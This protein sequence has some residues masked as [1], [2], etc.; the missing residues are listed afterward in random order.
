MGFFS[1]LAEGLTKTRNY[2]MNSVSNIFTGHDIIDDDVYEA[3][4][5]LKGQGEGAKDKGSC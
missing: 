2:I 1:K 5:E 3:L 4:E